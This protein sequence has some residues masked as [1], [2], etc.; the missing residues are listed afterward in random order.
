[1]KILVHLHIYYYDQIP[2]FIEKLSNISGVAWDLFITEAKHNKDIEKIFNNLGIKINYIETNNIG[3]DI[4]PFIKVIKSV[5][6]DDYDLILKLHTKNSREQRCKINGLN[7]NGYQWRNE[8]VDSLLLD[9]KHFSK[10]INLFRKN[11]RLGLICSFWLYSR[12]SKNRPEDLSLLQSELDRLGFKHPGDHFCAGSMFMAKAELYNFL[13]IDNI[14]ASLF[15]GTAKTK[16]TG[17]LAHVYERILSMVPNEHFYIV[18]TIHT[19]YLR[20]LYIMVTSCIG[21]LLEWLF[22]ISI[23]GESRQKYMILFGIKFHLR[24]KRSK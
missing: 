19:N 7:L 2:Y 14:Q 5:N 18:K 23:I 8:L 6:L 20:S 16:S 21:P 17:S 3:Y 10:L 13:Q 4:W 15:E 1:M 24:K 9:K 22:S 11:E 12:K